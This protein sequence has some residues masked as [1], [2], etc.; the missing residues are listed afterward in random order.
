[1][2]YHE[3]HQQ[4]GGVERGRQGEGWRKRVKIGGVPQNRKR[5]DIGKKGAVVI[6]LGQFRP[7]ARRR[8]DGLGG[9]GGDRMGGRAVNLTP[10]GIRQTG[11]GD[12]GML[13]GHLRDVEPHGIDAAAKKE[14]ISRNRWRTHSYKTAM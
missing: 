9:T 3:P 4:D 8:E 13:S 10:G 12:P 6:V 5:S 7:G 1:V 2:Q 11:I 14:D